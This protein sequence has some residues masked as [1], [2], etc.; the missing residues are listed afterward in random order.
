METNTKQLRPF[1]WSSFVYYLCIV[2]FVLWLARWHDD[3]RAQNNC[4]SVTL[5]A[6]TGNIGGG[7]LAIG[8]SATGTVSV[9]GALQ[10]TPCRAAASDGTNIAALGMSVDCQITA[11]G[12]ATVTLVAIVVLTPPAKTY[13]VRVSQ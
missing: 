3:V 7:L 8:G 4:S 9:S 11:N 5:C 12:T 2:I 6:T 13:N 10:G 1:P